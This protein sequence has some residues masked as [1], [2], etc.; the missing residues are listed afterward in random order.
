LARAP[1]LHAPYSTPSIPTVAQCH[2]PLIFAKWF[3]SAFPWH[4]AHVDLSFYLCFFS[5]VN[6]LVLFEPLLPRKLAFRSVACFGCL[7]PSFLFRL[8]I[9]L[10]PYERHLPGRS[11]SFLFRVLFSTGFLN[12][13]SEPVI[14]LSPSFLLA[15]PS[16]FFL[17]PSRGLL[18]TVCFS[19]HP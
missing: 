1:P 10:F 6:S 5:L 4:S 15:P 3:F 8:P 18:V 12:P 11:S 19:F 16:P 9:F 13:E 7:Y 17:Q 2:L 14:P